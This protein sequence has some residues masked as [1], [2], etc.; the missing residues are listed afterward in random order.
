MKKIQVSARTVELTIALLAVFMIMSGV[1]LYA[2]NEPARLDGALAAQIETDL[3]HAMTVYAENCAVCHGMAGEGIGSNPALDQPALRVTDF[4][5]LYKIIARGLYGTAMPAWSQEDGGPLSDYQLTQLVLLIQQGDWAATQDRVVN[6]GLAPLIPFTVEP[7]PEVMANL[8]ELPGGEVLAAGITVYA[9]ECVACHGPDGA[10][11]SLAPALNDPAVREKSVTE[12][13]RAIRTGISGTLMAGWQ[14]VLEDEQITAVLNLIQNWDTV[15]VGAIP[16]PERLLP[17]TAESLA[18]GSELYAANCAS[19]HGPEGQGT[20]RAPA[21]NVKGYLGETSDLALEQIVTLGVP[22]TAMPAWGDRM[23]AADIQAIVGFMRAWE[24]AAPE[25][26]EMARG[27]GGPWWQTGA[28]SPAGQSGARGG[29]GGGGPWWSTQGGQPP[30]Q[31]GQIASDPAAQAQLAGP[32]AH[33]PQQPLD[34]AETQPAA[35]LEM[36]PQVTAVISSVMTTTTHTHAEGIT[37]GPPEWAGAGQTAA[38]QAHDAET[39]GPPWAQTSEPLS[40]WESQ[41]SR[42]RFL[43]FWSAALALG[44]IA[45]GAAGTWL[46]TRKMRVISDQV[47]PE[48]AS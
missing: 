9:Q 14:N 25:V 2:L 41:D 47:A 4:D 17:V 16:E 38:A 22:G 44:L 6:L 10:G 48:S 29:N 34:I 30:G 19:C 26:A 3:G 32:D 15:P 23:P 24:P 21:L 13:E 36:E 35:L 28:S 7:D 5:A 8:A 46:V 20:P 45:A 31:Q 12:L 37:G 39:G 40:W 1:L 33:A 43:I 11:T 42:A 18:L 27:G